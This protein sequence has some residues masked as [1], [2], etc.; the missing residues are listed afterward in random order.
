MAFPFQLR[1]YVTF[2]GPLQLDET[3]FS[4]ELTSLEGVWPTQI[5]V[6]LVPVSPNV[7]MLF[8][9]DLT[10]FAQFHLYG[11]VPQ[12]VVLE[13]QA[14]AKLPS[15]FH[16]VLN[17]VVNGNTIANGNIIVNKLFTVNG[18]TN[19]NGVLNVKSVSK[20]YGAQNLIGPTKASLIILDNCGNV[21]VE[22]AL[23]KLMPYKPFDVPHPNK[24]GHRLRHAC[25]EGPEVGI[26]FR[27][28]LE[29]KSVIDLPDY[30]RGF[31]DPD[32]ITVN[33]TP[34]G[35]YQEL[36]VQDIQ[37]G[38]KVVVRNNA[39]GPINCHYTIYAERIDVEKLVVEYEG[40]SAADYPADDYLRL[41][42]RGWE[43]SELNWKDKEE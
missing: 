8:Y 4:Y 35:S 15:Y 2:T 22:I 41:K 7:G 12:I 5:P 43:A 16:N 25:I 30:W 34:Y 32:S 29:N 31:V 37:W 36:F 11:P 23:A 21:A 42:D 19:I 17:S 9:R 13:K 10:D 28:K 33:L 40:E 27:G 26:Y 1:N 38:Q 24:E 39:G 3:A 14:G 20:F 6:N 18:V